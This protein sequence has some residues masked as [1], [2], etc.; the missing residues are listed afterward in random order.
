[1]IARSGDGRGS[2][3]TCSMASLAPIMFRAEM[4]CEARSTSTAGDEETSPGVVSGGD[5]A[6]VV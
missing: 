5:E 3:V 4:D 1:M 6:R 2:S